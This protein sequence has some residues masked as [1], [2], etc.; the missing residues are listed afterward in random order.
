M[1]KGS[2]KIISLTQTLSVIVDSCT[3]WSNCQGILH[4]NL[5]LLHF[6]SCSGSNLK[7]VVFQVIQLQITEVEHISSVLYVQ[8]LKGLSPLNNCT[9][10]RVLGSL[11]IQKWSYS[12]EHNVPASHF[13]QCQGNACIYSRIF[14]ESEMECWYNAELK[15]KRYSLVFLMWWKTA[16]AFFCWQR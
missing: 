15:Q 1:C 16:Y 13:V 3:I 14:Y 6:F 9:F 10:A 5:N 2:V 7:L 12:Q 4:S 11:S 8:M